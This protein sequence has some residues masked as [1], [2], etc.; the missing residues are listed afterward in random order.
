MLTFVSIERIRDPREFGALI[1]KARRARGFN[2]IELASRA[3]I[4]RSGLQKIEE[5]R[6]SPSIET[7]MRLLRTLSL[8]L[9]LVTRGDPF[10]DPARKSQHGD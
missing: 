6:G 8:D 2:Q 10:V 7:A 9:G 3:N 4:S 5:G 1:R